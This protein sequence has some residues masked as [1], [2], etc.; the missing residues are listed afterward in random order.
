MYKSRSYSKGLDDPIDPK[1]KREQQVIKKQMYSQEVATKYT[2]KVDEE[3]RLELLK[4]IEE[5]NKKED[6]KIRKYLKG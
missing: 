1:K 4:N 6:H 5:L 2:P 3:K